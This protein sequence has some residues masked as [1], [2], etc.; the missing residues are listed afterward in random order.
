[1]GHD[2]HI[3]HTHHPLLHC[4]GHDSK[5]P[6]SSWHVQLNSTRHSRQTWA[7][8]L[9]PSC[10]WYDTMLAR[11]TPQTHIPSV[12]SNYTAI[13]AQ[14]RCKDME[15]ESESKG[16]AITPKSGWSWVLWGCWSRPSALPAPHPETSLPI[17]SFSQSATQNPHKVRVSLTQLT[18]CHLQIK[19]CNWELSSMHHPCACRQQSLS[20]SHR[21]K[22]LFLYKLQL[23]IADNAC[24]Q[25]Y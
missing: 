25:Y 13:W 22:W 12:E 23:Y 16:Q 7:F 9:M 21:I 15:S 4:T 2:Q 11:F 18:W 10:A 24:N 5:S 14:C 17:P 3:K 6:W 8:D 1:M 19:S 20:L